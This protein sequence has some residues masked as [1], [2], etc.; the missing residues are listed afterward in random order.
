MAPG[1]PGVLRMAA[2]VNAAGARFDDAARYLDQYGDEDESG[3]VLHVNYL[4]GRIGDWKRFHKR[5]PGFRVAQSTSDILGDDATSTGLSPGSSDSSDDDS[6]G[7][8]S[9]DAKKKAPPRMTMVDVVIIRSEELRATDKGINLLSGL[10]STLT[11]TLFAL[12][13]VRTINKF[14]AE[15]RVTSFTYAPS[16]SLSATYSLNIF[17][18]SNGYNEVLARPSLVALDGKKSEFFTG[19]VFHVEIQGA[20]GSEGS[21]EDVP[22]GIKLDVTPKF[23]S[24]DM[25]ELEVSAARAFIEG[26]SSQANFNNFAQITKTLVTANVV[27][28]FGDTLVISG[29]SE[30]ETEKLNQGVPFLQEIPGVQYLFSHE[31]TADITK[32]VLILMTPRKPS[33]THEDGSPKIDRASPPDAAAK[34]PNLAEL[35]DRPGWFK[36]AANLDAVYHHLKDVT[37]FKEFRTGDVKLERWQEKYGLELRIKRALEFL[38]F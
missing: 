37:L 6:N 9:G 19:A 25:V 29:L 15:T 28:K 33:Y 7:N 22:V 36:P 4:A 31:D 38:Y 12:S 32:S 11:G 17:N 18:D 13:D 26:R 27:M 23:L 2:L 24:N 30:K 35:K 14:A 34:Q 20:A 8:G 21:V 3:G 5:N 16:L 10:S 1:D